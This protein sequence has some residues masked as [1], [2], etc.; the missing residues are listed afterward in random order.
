MERM[1]L[2][3]VSNAITRHPNS[4]HHRGAGRTTK[5]QRGHQSRR[6]SHQSFHEC[7]WNQKNQTTCRRCSQK[8]CRYRCRWRCRYHLSRNRGRDGNRELGDRRVHVH[9]LHRGQTK[10]KGVQWFGAPCLRTSDRPFDC[11]PPT[12]QTDHEG[13]SCYP[14]QA[15]TAPNM[16]VRKR[17]NM[18]ASKEQY[19]TSLTK[20]MAVPWLP[21]RP[22][23]PIRCT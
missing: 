12:D 21:A 13:C 14:T 18:Q 9:D 23:R 4:C 16:V 6:S 17:E 15:R 1:H 20:A 2:P 8:H 11:S 7:R 10:T 19:D 22:V 3:S 5:G